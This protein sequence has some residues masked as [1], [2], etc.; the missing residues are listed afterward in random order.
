M[1]DETTVPAMCGFTF[2]TLT[3]YRNPS[4]QSLTCHLLAE[5]CCGSMQFF[6][7]TFKTL[8]RSSQ[9]LHDFDPASH[10]RFQNPCNFCILDRFH[11]SWQAVVTDLWDSIP[12]NILLQGDING[13][14]SVLQD[15]RRCTV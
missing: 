4:I 7:P 15:I 13:W 8:I 11:C 14:Q 5:E 2:Q 10:L 3:D 1:D 9:R 6:C 12:P